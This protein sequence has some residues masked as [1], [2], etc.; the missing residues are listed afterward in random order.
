MIDVVIEKT[1]TGKLDKYFGLMFR[2][3]PKVVL[4]KYESEKMIQIHTIGTFVP[5]DVFWLDEDYMVCFW[6]RMFP[7]QISERVKA[8][9][10]IEAPLGK[11]DIRIGDQVNLI[12]K[13]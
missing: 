5:L 3:K 4:F 10:I 9:Y 12:E 6:Q 13:A 1:C 11:L 7:M 8:K 2:P